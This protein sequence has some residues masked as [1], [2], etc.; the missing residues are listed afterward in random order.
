MVLATLKEET[1]GEEIFLL[2]FRKNSLL[3][4]A[5]VLERELMISGLNI[6]IIF[7]NDDYLANNVAWPVLSKSKLIT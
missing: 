4:I 6:I 7:T 2:R 1:S 3:S 5:V